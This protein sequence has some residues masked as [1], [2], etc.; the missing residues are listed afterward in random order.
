MV[1][2]TGVGH[3]TMVYDAVETHRKRKSAYRV[4]YGQARGIGKGD[5]IGA[6]NLGS[7]VVLVWEK[8]RIDLGQ[9]ASGQK[10]R[11]GQPLARASSR[12]SG[13]AA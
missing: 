7:T 10:I 11:L 3:M 2:A 4:R 1:A 13:A 12:S 8:G 5:E 9:V 6:F